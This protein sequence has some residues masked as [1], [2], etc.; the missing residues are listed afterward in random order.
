[1]NASD[2]E[3]YR[4]DVGA[5]LLGA[6]PDLER[7]AFERHLA[8]CHECREE[9]ER[10]RP[11]ADALPRAVE[12]LAPPASLKE[13]LME[14]IRD[15]A[16]GAARAPA[17]GRLGGLVRL[18]WR[19]RP[20]VAWAAA[21]L[22]VAVGVATG[23]GIARSIDDARTVT[24]QVD[25]AQLPGASARLSLPDG[26]DDGAILRVAGMPAPGRGRVYQA[27]VQRDG[28]VAPAPTFEVGPRGAG[29]VAVPG[30][31]TDAEAV[32]VT[33]ERRGGARVPSEDPVVTALL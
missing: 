17:G 28:E 5:Y 21:A 20:A 12:P 2:H 23:F 32:L 7:Q 25:R 15:D 6:M 26:G 4:E 18:P 9:V 27:W 19:V 10:L 13:S 8:G 11:A 33:R 3:R 29:A 16:D 30:D 1:M 22:L 31:L 14:A 24:A